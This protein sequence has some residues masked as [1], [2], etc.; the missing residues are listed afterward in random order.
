MDSAAA[1]F[2]DSCSSSH[3]PLFFNFIALYTSLPLKRSVLT[4]NSMFDAHMNACLT[5]VE[6]KLVKKCTAG[7]GK[8]SMV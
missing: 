4:E 7:N 6:K 2:S 3:T 1:V 8:M 5:N